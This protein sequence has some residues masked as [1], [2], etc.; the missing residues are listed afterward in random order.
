MSVL[1]KSLVGCI[2]FVGSTAWGFED[3]MAAVVGDSVITE[4]QVKKSMRLF[5]KMIDPKLIQGKDNATFRDQ[6]LDHMIDVSVQLN[7][8]KR[9]GIS[10]SDQEKQTVR[11]NL[12]EQRQADVDDLEDHLRNE[13]VD[14]HAFFSHFEQQMLV[15]KIQQM[16][17]GSQV[18]VTEKDIDAVRADFEARLTE[19]FVEDI[20]FESIGSSES[21]KQTKQAAKALSSSWAK[22]THNKWNVP[23]GSRMIQFKWKKLAEMPEVFQAHIKAMDQGTCA[24]PLLTESGVHV[25][26]L[27]KKRQANGMPTEAQL[28]EYVFGQNMHKEVTRWISDLKQQQYI[29][30]T[31]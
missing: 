21:L 14:P 23:K 1:L 30:K 19:Y 27:I 15:Q 7:V 29:A 25:L 24:Q 31:A 4:S 16:A 13:G 6:I 3:S 5:K 20:V 12:A 11:K 10:L 28:K 22:G 9:A 8:A 17:V 18:K 2:L 26:K